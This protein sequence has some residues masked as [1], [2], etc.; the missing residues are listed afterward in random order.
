MAPADRRRPKVVRL[1]DLSGP[2]RRVVV[3]LL[4][5]ARA[6]DRKKVGHDGR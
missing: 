4:D 3:A 2:Q 5:A 1:A 6:A